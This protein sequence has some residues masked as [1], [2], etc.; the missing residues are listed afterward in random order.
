MTYGGCLSGKERYARHN[1]TTT[2]QTLPRIFSPTHSPTQSILTPV[3]RTLLVALFFVAGCDRPIETPMPAAAD[4]PA[5]QALLVGGGSSH[6]FDRWFDREDTAV[7]RKAG[8]AVVYTDQP[9]DIAAAL[10][11]LDVLILANNQPIEDPSIRSA[12]EAFAGAGMGLVLYHPAVWYNWKD[13]PAYNRDLVGGGSESHGPY[14]PFTVSIQ[15]SSHAITRGVEPSFTLD[16]EL[17][18]FAIDP[19][20]PG[21]DVLATGREAASGTDFPVAWTVRHPSARIVGITLGHDGAA[22]ELPAFR[23]ILVNSVRWAA[24]NVE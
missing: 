19:A 21:I 6:D 12:I 24:G 11:T 5:I 1:L 4:H 17:Y 10:D 15:D 16:D 3:I 23:Q 18:R 20:G 7:L 2:I 13:W 8:V 9:A 14:G 22:H